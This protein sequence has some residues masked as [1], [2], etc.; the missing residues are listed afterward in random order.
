MTAKRLQDNFL[1]S[2][3]IEGEFRV[4]TYDHEEG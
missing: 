3:W 2:L 1:Q 4:G